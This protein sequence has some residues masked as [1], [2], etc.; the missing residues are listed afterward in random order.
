[1]A[2]DAKARDQEETKTAI[3]QERDETHLAYNSPAKT[4]RDRDKTFRIRDETFVGL[5]M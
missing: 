5:K 3:S 2:R 1:L 4:R